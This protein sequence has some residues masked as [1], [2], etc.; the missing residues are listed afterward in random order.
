MQGGG[1]V[2]TW[3]PT[4]QNLHARGC[5]AETWKP[6]FQVLHM[7]GGCRNLEKCYPQDQPG[8]YRGKPISGIVTDNQDSFTFLKVAPSFLHKHFA[9]AF[10]KICLSLWN[11]S[12]NL[13]DLDFDTPSSWP[14]LVWLAS[15]PEWMKHRL[16]F[17]PT[18]FNG[19][20]MINGLIRHF[21]HALKNSNVNIAGKSKHYAKRAH[22]KFP[23]IDDRQGRFTASFSMNLAS[24]DTLWKTL[25]HWKFT[26]DQ[27]QADFTRT[28]LSR[29]VCTTLHN[30]Q[31]QCH[32]TIIISEC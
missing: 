21:W 17:D 32:T 20:H 25:Q 12:W 19:K 8:A 14:H 18:S 4:C 1:N 7:G 31:F 2:E 5:D 24:V 23:H 30:M 26:N 3:E 27:E 6:A 11:V 13:R 29:I 15:G 10:C 16:Q 9:R 28:V 22:L